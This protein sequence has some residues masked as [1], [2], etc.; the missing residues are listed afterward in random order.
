MKKNFATIITITGI[1]ISIISCK[2]KAKPAST[3]QAEEVTTTQTTTDN[4]LVDITA[5]TIVW[6]GFKP[7]GMHNGTIDLE[8]GIFNTSNGKISG[9]RFLIKMNTIKDADS[10]MKLENHLKSVDFFDVEK[11]PSATFEITGLNEVEGKTALSGNLTLKD[12]KNN[13]TFP[14]NVVNDNS[15]ITLTSDTFTIDRTKWNV[16]YKSKSIFSGLGDKF[17]D[18]DIELKISIKAAKL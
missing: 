16:Q 15:S 4:Y 1:I 3:T 7:T 14:V 2:N 13:V 9:G 17:I 6:K 12:V 5:S 8:S 18:D 11:H 10:S